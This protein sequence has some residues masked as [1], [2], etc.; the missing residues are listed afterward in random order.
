M[1]AIVQSC[2]IIPSLV[3]CNQTTSKCCFH[4]LLPVRSF[5]C[6]YGP[7]IYGLTKG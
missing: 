7:T 6:K 5:K 4:I 2:T 1:T 3:V